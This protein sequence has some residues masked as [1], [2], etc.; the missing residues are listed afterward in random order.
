MS[1]PEI[2]I[3]LV[4]LMDWFSS[5]VTRQDLLDEIVELLTEHYWWSD[6]GVEVLM[7][8]S[9]VTEDPDEDGLISYEQLGE[10][11]EAARERWPEEA[12]IRAD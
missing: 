4:A 8:I 3:R 5:D 9:L 2:W 11:F 7:S 12:A 1:Y 6:F 10:D